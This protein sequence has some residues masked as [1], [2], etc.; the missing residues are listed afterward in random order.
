[1]QIAAL[2]ICPKKSGCSKAVWDWNLS[3]LLGKS[4]F[5]NFCSRCLGASPSFTELSSN[6]SILPVSTPQR[7]PNL[8]QI[9]KD[10][11]NSHHQQAVI[12]S[13]LSLNA[14]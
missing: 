2:Q 1:M 8:R 7:R 12:K 5:W 3:L 13:H 10:P 6:P 14:H 9:K 4:W 11:I